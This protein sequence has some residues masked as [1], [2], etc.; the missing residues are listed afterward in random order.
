MCK[1]ITL[2]FLFTLCISGNLYSQYELWNIQCT[3]RPLT[4]INFISPSQA[5]IYGGDIAY[6]SINGGE[7]WSFPLI[8]FPTIG[9]SFSRISFVDS[10]YGWACQSSSSVLKTI[11][12]GLGWTSIPVG[13]SYYR[14]NTIYF[15]NRNTGWIAGQLSNYDNL[16]A[17]TTNGGQNWH[18]IFNLKFEAGQIYMLNEYKGFAISTLGEVIG[19]LL[20]QPR[21]VDIAGITLELVI[22]P[23]N[24][25]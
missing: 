4:S 22:Q 3:R 6:K 19:I 17:K 7:T 1:K 5:W 13:L 15:M 12:G 21:M 16:I 24:R 18:P 11:N 2:L 14:I 25:F 10:L 8:Q 23:V 9:G 20:H